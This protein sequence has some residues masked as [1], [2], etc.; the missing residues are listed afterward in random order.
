MKLKR[1]ELKEFLDEKVELY[2]RPAFIEAD[3]ISIP[4]QFT[5]KQDIEVNGLLAK[6]LQVQ[7]WTRNY[8]QSSSDNRLTATCYP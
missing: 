3:P 1:E 6:R 8:L 2:N 7:E 4:L 5:K